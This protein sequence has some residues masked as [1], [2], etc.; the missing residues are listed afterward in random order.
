MGI[1]DKIDQ[2]KELVERSKKERGTFSRN[3]FGFAITNQEQ[4]QVISEEE[5]SLLESEYGLTLS[6][7]YRAYLTTVANGGY[8]PLSGLFT[9]QDSLALNHM[10]ET[11][12]AR[13]AGKLIVQRY[14]ENNGYENYSDRTCKEWLKEFEI[15]EFGKAPVLDDYFA[16][17]IKE[18]TDTNESI[19]FKDYLEWKPVPEEYWVEYREGMLKHILLLS[20]GDYYRTEIGLVLD[21]EH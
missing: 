4:F 1:Q 20:Y 2:L 19:V 9:V 13:A 12:F 16:S 14:L 3:D 17:E 6:E 18:K 15:K 7:E 5:L 21:G 8:H 10:A 11:D